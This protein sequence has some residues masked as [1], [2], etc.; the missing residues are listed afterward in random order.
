MALI[1]ANAALGT[2]Y[3]KP[4]L[5]IKGRWASVLANQFLHKT[6][7]FQGKLGA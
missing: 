2:R 5:H 3:F 7:W 4:L 1:A 6:D